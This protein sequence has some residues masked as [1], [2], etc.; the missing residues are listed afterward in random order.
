M[1]ERSNPS[2][3]VVDAR[4]L[5]IRLLFRALGS[6]VPTT[7]VTFHLNSDDLPVTESD[8][9]EA[10]GWSLISMEIPSRSFGRMAALYA[11]WLQRRLKEKLPNPDVVVFTQPSQRSLCRH[12]GAARRIYYVADDYRWGYGLNPDLVEAWERT[13]VDHVE[14]VVCVSNVLAGYMIERLHVD[15][16]KVLVS[17]NGMPEFLIPKNGLSRSELA[18]DTDLPD[19][20]PLVGVCG[21]INRRVRLD[22]LRGLIDTLPWVN[23][24][25]VGP[26]GELSDTQLEDWKYLLEHDRCTIIGEVN[27]YDLFSYAAYVDVGLIPLT[28][29]GIN[30]ASSPTRFFTQLPFGQP[31]IASEGSMQLREF[32]PLV[33]IVKT[34]SELVDH[35]NELYEIDFNDALADKRRE[36]ARNH[37]WEKRAETFYR[38]LICN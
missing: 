10:R 25:L 19:R 28:S 35:M 5:W 26:R 24:L 37:T 14:N 23:L 9:A 38:E 11:P 7:G 16:K 8:L 2:V 33:K 4:P 17:A 12:F 3:L 15:P 22:W 30:P 13:M 34:L 6:F 32:E 36:T 1:L 21:I 18:R 31:I 29:D 27:Y 20:R